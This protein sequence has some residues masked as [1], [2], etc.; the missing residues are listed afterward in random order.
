MV[1]KLDRV[2]VDTA[3]AS[4]DIG[5][6]AFITNARGDVSAETKSAERVDSR[7]VD[8]YERI[9]DVYTKTKTE[10]YGPGE[11]ANNWIASKDQR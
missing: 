6:S 10:K 1:S 3:K 7:I 2:D 5:G 11:I 8:T 4:L 9:S